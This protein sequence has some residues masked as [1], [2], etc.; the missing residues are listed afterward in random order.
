[1]IQ[2]IQATVVL[3]SIGRTK[4]EVGPTQELSLNLTSSLTCSSAVGLQVDMMVKLYL[5]TNIWDQFIY[6]QFFVC[7]KVNIDMKSNFLIRNSNSWCCECSVIFTG[8]ISIETQI[9]KIINTWD[10]SMK[11]PGDHIY[12]IFSPCASTSSRGL[13]S[14]TGVLLS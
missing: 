12:K 9:L 1:M 10:R 8:S 11:I 4:V 13:K 5:E 2:V 14:S 7:V 6:H 3:S